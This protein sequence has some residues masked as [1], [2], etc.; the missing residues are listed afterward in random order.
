VVFSDRSNRPGYIFSSAE[1]ATKFVGEVGYHAA[2]FLRN[3]HDT[4]SLSRKLYSLGILGVLSYPDS[5]RVKLTFF[6]K[7]RFQWMDHEPLPSLVEQIQ[8]H[9]GTA[10]AIIPQIEAN[11]AM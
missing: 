8:L 10:S 6:I 7:D 5:V 2:L 11:I 1:M 9:F 4:T 3:R